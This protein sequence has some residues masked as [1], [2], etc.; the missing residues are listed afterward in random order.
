MSWNLS[1]RPSDLFSCC[2]SF[3]IYIS[4]TFWWNRGISSIRAS[5]STSGFVQ[6]AKHWVSSC[7]VSSAPWDG[8]TLVAEVL[9]CLRGKGCNRVVTMLCKGAFVSFAIR[10]SNRVIAKNISSAGRE[11]ALEPGEGFHGR[12]WGGAG[13]GEVRAAPRVLQRPCP[14]S[15]PPLAAPL[16]GF[17]WS[18]SAEGGRCLFL[19]QHRLGNPKSVCRFLPGQWEGLFAQGVQPTAECTSEW[20]RNQTTADVWL[21]QVSLFPY[22]QRAL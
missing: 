2:K 5:R 4:I 13:P 14:D 16:G 21:V 3:Q 12:S 11:A 8:R 9:L 6:D 1:W 20:T 19:S 15:L 7:V 22:L 10:C 17:W 18:P